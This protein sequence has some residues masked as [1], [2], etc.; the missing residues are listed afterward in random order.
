MATSPGGLL[1]RNSHHLMASSHS[2]TVEQV[3]PSSSSS[4][5]TTS[6]YCDIKTKRKIREKTIKANRSTPS[7]PCPVMPRDPMTDGP[8]GKNSRAI[9]SRRPLTRSVL[10]ASL[11]PLA[12][13]G[14]PSGSVSSKKG[15]I[16]HGSPSIKPSSISHPRRLLANHAP[17]P[18]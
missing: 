14:T 7:G 18:K 12:G 1:G 3:P 2:A 9:A 15:L 5:P 11:S 13:P 4:S 17:L 10:R 6:S 8:P 16:H